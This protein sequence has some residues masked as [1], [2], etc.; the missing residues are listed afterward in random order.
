MVLLNASWFVK[1]NVLAMIGMSTQRLASLKK[2]SYTSNTFRIETHRH[3]LHEIINFLYFKKQTQSNDT[4][5]FW[6]LSI[7]NIRSCTTKNDHVTSLIAI[8]PFYDKD[9]AVVRRY[10]IPIIE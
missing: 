9:V 7:V 10:V 1:N 6:I 8:Q 2:E 5:N 3:R 4:S